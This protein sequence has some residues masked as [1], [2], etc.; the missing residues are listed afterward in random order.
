MAN[1]SPAY[2]PVFRAF[3][4]NGNPLA[5]GKLYSYAAGTT[6]PLATYPDATGGTPNTN[7]VELDAN[8]E[9][10]VWLGPDAYKFVLQDATGAVLWTVDGIKSLDELAQAYADTLRTD[11]ANTADPAKGAALVGYKSPLTGGTAR[12]VYARLQDSVSV[13]DFGAVGDGVTDDTEAIQACITAIL[14]KDSTVSGVNRPWEHRDGQYR[15]AIY[16][17]MG[18]YIISDTLLLLTGSMT[19]VQGLVMYGPGKIR[20]NMA[21]FMLQVDNTSY[22]AIHDMIFLNG[23][24]AAGSGCIQLNGC[25]GALFSNVR[26]YGGEIGISQ[27]NGN[28]ILYHRCS[29]MYAGEGYRGHNSTDNTANAFIGCAIER[30]TVYGLNFANSAA[31]YGNWSVRDCYFEDNP[32]AIR[33]YNSQYGRIDGCYIGLSNAGHKGIVVDGTAT[34]KLLHVSQIRFQNNSGGGTVYGLDSGP[35]GGTVNT[36]GKLIY[37]S[38]TDTSTVGSVDLLGLAVGFRNEYARHFDVAVV[39]PVFAGTGTPTGWTLLLGTASVGTGIDPYGTGTSYVGSDGA[40]ND[41]VIYQ[42]VQFPAYSLLRFSYWAKNIAN[43]TTYRLRLTQAGSTTNI[44]TLDDK[45]PSGAE[46]REI[47]W[48]SGANTTARIEIRGGEF[49]FL[50]VEDVT[51]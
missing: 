45:N 14:E 40:G 32:V 24:T 12:T 9:A 30:N 41:S 17:P 36:N 15:R 19:S 3:D 33:S 39:N 44:K 1:F 51:N 47:Y 18:E 31:P 29:I 26:T 37:S 50:R 43:A 8:G 38:L 4:A 10:N 20:A 25:Y 11:L 6:T 48:Y 34:P 2:F 49:G 13:K 27:V 35:Y 16:F 28:G 22:F 23:S 42:V 21:K 5:G 46:Y 7:P